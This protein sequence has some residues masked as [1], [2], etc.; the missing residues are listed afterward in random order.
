MWLNK[1]NISWNSYWYCRDIKDDPKVRKHIILEMDAYYYCMYVKDD[2]EVRKYI[3]RYIYLKY[4][5]ELRKIKREQK[6]EHECFE[7][8]YIETGIYQT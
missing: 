3:N 7:R 2:P 5:K 4:L 1:K 8:L 6:N